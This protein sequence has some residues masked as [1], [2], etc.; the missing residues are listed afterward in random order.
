MP[1][2]DL[3][4]LLN[5]VRNK[6][7]RLLDGVGDAESRW[8]PAGLQNTIL[9]HAGHVFVVNEHMT[10]SNIGGKCVSYPE[11]WFECFSWKSQ[12]ALVKRWP[13]LSQVIGQLQEQ[14]ERIRAVVQGLTAEQLGQM[15]GDPARKRSLRWCILH[16]LHDEANH[17]GE[18]W[19][20]KK[21][22]GKRG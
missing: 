11:G 14:L 15:V 21:M 10:F 5:D 13:A 17:Q 1:D 8:A 4:L 7:L 18:M 3:V 22:Y 9:W 2:E 6:T 16:A 12:P 19:L 20:L